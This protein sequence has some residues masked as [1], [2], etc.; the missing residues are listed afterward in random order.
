MELNNESRKMLRYIYQHP[1]V[2]CL[3]L[4]SFKNKGINRAR[5]DETMR[6]LISQKLISCRSASCK[7]ADA[8]KKELPYTGIDGYLVVTNLGEI[9]AE[10][11]LFE[12]HKWIYSEFRAWITLAISVI[13]LVL[14]IINTIK[15]F[16]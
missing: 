8:D 5:A 14:S 15:I 9:V 4:L 6:S 1:Y 13:S 2:S 11:I 12:Y 10:N 3:Q 7:E 16:V